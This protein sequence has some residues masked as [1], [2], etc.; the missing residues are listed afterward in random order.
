MVSQTLGVRSGSELNW[1]ADAPGQSG[2]RCVAV[3]TVHSDGANDSDEIHRL[4]VVTVVIGKAV[5]YIATVKL[6]F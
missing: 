6:R 5:T 4:S 3:S 2:R 1:M